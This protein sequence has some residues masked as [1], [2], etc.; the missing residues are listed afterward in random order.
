MKISLIVL[1]YNGKKHLKEYFTSVFKQTLI[2]DEIIMMDNASTDDSIEYTRKNFP[3]V[4]IIKNSFNA[5]TALGSNIAFEYSTGDVV[6]FQSND[7][8]LDKNCVKYLIKAIEENKN[9]GIATSILLQHAKFI[10]QKKQIIDNAGGIADIYG[11]GMQKYPSKEL[12]NIPDQEEVFFSYGGS[13]IIK[14]QLFK[15]IKGFDQR[16]F[17][18]NDDIDLSWRVRLMG[19]KIVYV[20][21]S[22]I[23]H[24]VSATLGTL[25]QRSTKRYWS[26]RNAMR[27]LL[28]N[29]TFLN[30]IIFFPIYLILLFAEMG[31]FLIKKRFDLFLAD[32]K[33]ILWNIFYLPETLLMRLYIQSNKKNN[34]IYNL[35]NKKSYK[36]M[37]FNSFKKTI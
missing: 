21:K 19:K 18:L 20:K 36:L 23:Y 32:L 17:T 34:N 28:K 3:E 35:L 6:I 7:M 29:H 16:F 37:L 9:I 10:K 33:A 25:F 15:Q 27:T 30:L 2:P 11:L 24:K 14:R 5:G 4:K 1:N 22:I 12:K 8:R 13:F 26:E 31:F